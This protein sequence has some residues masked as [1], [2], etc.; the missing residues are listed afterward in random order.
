MFPI[1]R[2]LVSNSIKFTNSGG[3]V[4]LNAKRF[5]NF[6]EISVADTGVGIAKTNLDK[7]FKL[8]Q[9]VST[10]GTANE[11]GTGLGLILC[12][13]MVEKHCGKIWV[14]SEA[15]KGTTFYFTLPLT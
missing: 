8:D 12:K 13:E 1:V 10:K 5:D 6:I 9:N 2:N 14:E 15:G 3:K 4:T 7:L 11:E